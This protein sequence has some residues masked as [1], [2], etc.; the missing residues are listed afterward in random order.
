MQSSRGMFYT[1]TGGNGPAIL[2]IHGWGVCTR[3]FDEVTELLDGVRCIAVDLPGF[4]RSMDLGSEIPCRPPDLAAVVHELIE[5]LG[6]RPVVCGHSMGGMVAQELALEYADSVKGIILVDTAADPRAERTWMFLVPLSPL[7]YV[8]G[9]KPCM[10]WFAKTYA[11]NRA[12]TPE[13]GIDLLNEIV[14]QNRKPRLRGCI[15]GMVR[16]SSVDRLKDIKMPTLI[17]HGDRDRMLNVR[18]SEILVKGIPG[19]RRI[20]MKG[21]GHSPTI[22][23]PVET[24]K[25][26]QDFM[27][28]FSS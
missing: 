16:W 19:S 6:I 7:M 2:F 13:R 5:E 17:I 24:T 23:R 14:T 27:T 22:E 1:D 8:F 3:Y 10:R 9:F 28:E 18:Q 12:E 21:C 25:A 11:V 4:G 26:I 20:V 15:K